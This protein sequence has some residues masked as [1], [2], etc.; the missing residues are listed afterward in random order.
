MIR[1]EK[2]LDRSGNVFVNHGAVCTIS[3]EECRN[4]VKAGDDRNILMELSR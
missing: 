2:V 4:Q 1:A 3:S